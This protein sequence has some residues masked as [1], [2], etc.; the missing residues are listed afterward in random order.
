MNAQNS[1]KCGES[2]Q[3][4]Q[5]KQHH[6]TLWR[7]TIQTNDMPVNKKSKKQS[8]VVAC[9]LPFSM[10]LLTIIVPKTMDHFLDG[11]LTAF[12]PCQLKQL[13]NEAQYA[14]GSQVGFSNVP[15]LLHIL[16]HI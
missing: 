12:E 5:E 13:P 16:K 8:T 14:E 11:L 2:T 6:E 1:P 10:L 4:L 9:P 3:A 15:H 7:K